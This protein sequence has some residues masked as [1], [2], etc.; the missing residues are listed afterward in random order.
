MRVSV[1]VAPLAATKEQSLLLF[2]G[3]S[4]GGATA[5]AGGT[6][7]APIPASG[8]KLKDALS[9]YPGGHNDPFVGSQGT[10]EAG[11]CRIDLDGY[12]WIEL[13]GQVLSRALEVGR[14]SNMRTEDE[15]CS[16][17]RRPEQLSSPS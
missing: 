15:S 6:A 2:S 11:S 17:A 12:L 13:K 16:A 3:G 10:I 7:T 5:A 14:I 9:Y 8:S 4:V 1:D